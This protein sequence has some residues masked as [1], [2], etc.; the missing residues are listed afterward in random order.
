MSE[1]LAI[2]VDNALA[3]NAKLLP[4]VASASPR[5]RDVLTFCANF[6]MAGIGALFLTGEGTEFRTQLSKSGRAFVR[7]LGCPGVELPLLSQAQPFFD[8]VAA[9]DVDGARQIATLL[10]RDWGRGEEYE[11]DFL[12]PEYLMQRFFLGADPAARVALLDRWEAALQG[13]EDLR[14]PVCRALEGADADDFE[15]SLALLLREE[16]NDLDELH[17]LG[18]LA[19][20]VAATERHLSVLGLAMARLAEAAGLSVAT[21][22]PGVPSSAR[23]GGAIVFAADAWRDVG[24]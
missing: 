24:A 22:Y 8:A 5:L 11:E 19:P 23:D 20:E 14:L 1:F 6:R 13:S 17:D 3:D 16:R 21:E 7:Y 18:P 10:R 12:F 2:F 9:G 4:R 15:S